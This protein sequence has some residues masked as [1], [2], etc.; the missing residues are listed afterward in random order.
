MRDGF[1][2]RV[3]Q[4]VPD[5]VFVLDAT[6]ELLFAN[7]A[8]ERILSWSSDDWVGENVMSLV[9]P[10]DLEL[11]AVSLDSVAAKQVGTAI[12]VRVATGDRSW[13]LLE[14]IGANLL[15]D[16]DIKG[17]VFS[18]RDLT[19]RRR[20]DV[21]SNDNERFRQ[22]VQ[23][24][25]A[26]TM[27]IGADGRICG[28]SAAITRVLGH[29]PELIVGHR[30]VDLVAAQ[31]ADRVARMLQQAV[32][33]AG[34]STFDAYFA[35]ANGE[36]LVPLELAVVNLCDDPVVEGLVVSGHDI[37]PLREAQHQ[38]EHLASHDALTGLPNR[39]SFEDRLDSAL[40]RASRSRSPLA[41]LFVDVDGLKE[42]NDLYGHSAGDD[43]LRHM[44]RRLES[45]IRPGDTVARYGGDE[46]LIVAENTDHD[47]AIRMRDRIERALTTQVQIGP[48]AVQMRASVGVATTNDQSIPSELIAA[49]D[50]DMYS[51]KAARR[52]QGALADHGAPSSTLA[53]EY[54]NRG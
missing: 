23:H 3:L 2:E 40:A 46:F 15:D 45:V 8:A 43:L 1:A 42:A 20:W 13:R 31:D 14:V 52:R 29:D 33:V 39:A 30:L 11:V 26:V 10:D 35:H 17:I 47:Q 32:E 18:A 49:A 48:R 41:V 4:G 19:E 22:I 21:A 27:L 44:A 36:M 7:R 50:S 51:I 54:A 5:P 6:G 34:T 24:S 37:T 12:E 38:L 28:A 53:S 16:P 25:A 9:H